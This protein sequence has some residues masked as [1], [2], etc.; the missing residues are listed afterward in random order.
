MGYEYMKV[1]LQ[2]LDLHTQY[3]LL[4][5]R[6]AS[7]FFSALCE[8]EKVLLFLYIFVGY[9]HHANMSV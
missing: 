2:N 6:Y 7:H 3:I 1:S 4:K 5:V 9:S 8:P